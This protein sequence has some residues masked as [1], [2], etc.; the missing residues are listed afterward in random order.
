MMPRIAARGYS[1]GAGLAACKLDLEIVNL[2]KL[3]LE[4]VNLARL[5]LRRVSK[6]R[7]A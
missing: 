6:K 4:I 5:L 1:A 7:R 3:D 2:A